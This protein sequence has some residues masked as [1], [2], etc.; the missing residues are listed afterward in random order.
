MS[1]FEMEK[2]KRI[3]PVYVMSELLS[4]NR[5]ACVEDLQAADPDFIGGTNWDRLWPPCKRL[6]E[7]MPCMDEDTMKKRLPEACREL[8]KDD[9]KERQPERQT[10]RMRKI[11]GY[12]KRNSTQTDSPSD[13]ALITK[14][15]CTSLYL[16]TLPKENGL[17]LGTVLYGI[18]GAKQIYLSNKSKNHHFFN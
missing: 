4:E 3:L 13:D 5:K 8:L 17:L 7:K 10:M 11:M 18:R 12:V 2:L 6:L 1:C 16:R 9:A 14:S 15:R